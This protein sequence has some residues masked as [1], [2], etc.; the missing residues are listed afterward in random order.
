MKKL[1]IFLLFLICNL[2]SAICNHL[3]AVSETEIFST[4]CEFYKKSNYE[5]ALEQFLIIEKSYPSTN[6]F[7][8]LGNTYFRLGRIGLAMVYYEKAR[9]ISPADDDVNYNIKFIAQLIK[10]PDYEQSLISRFNINRLRL[11]FAISL[12]S[13]VVVISIKFVYP[14]KKMFW[15]VVVSVLFF[16]FFSALYLIKYRQQ[17]RQEA[18][19]INTAEVRSGPD[20]NFKVNFTVPEGKKVILLGTSGEGGEWLEIGVKSLGVR[21]W[22][23][24]KYIEII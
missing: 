8:N 20:T 1:Q 21:G 2:Q 17:A 14:F 12:F 10:D 6:L 9:K 13:F 15:L 23:E 22:V 3:Y 24:K 19:V 5:K 11:L 7:Y 16:G 4:G 18:V